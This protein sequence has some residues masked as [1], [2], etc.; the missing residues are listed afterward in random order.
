MKICL[1]IPC[2]NE[3]ESIKILYNELCETIKEINNYRVELLFIDDGS[4]D[5]TLEIIQNISNSD[6][7]VKF[8]SFSRNFGKES[9]ILAGLRFAKGD[10]I[11]VLDADLQHPPFALIN[12]IEA[13]EEGYDIAA[14]R[15]IDRNGEKKTYSWFARSFYKAINMM[16]QIKIHEGAQDFRI[17]KRKVVKAIINMP[18]YHRF[19]KGIFSWVG[20]KT[21]WFEHENRERVAGTTKWS[22][23]KSCRYA[24]DGIISF[25]TMPLRISLLTGF[26]VSMFGFV[27]ALYIV[28]K[29]LILGSDWPGFPTITSLILIMSGFILLSLGIIG[30]YIS[31]IYTEVKNRPIYII[32]KTNI[33]F[34]EQ[35][36]ER[37]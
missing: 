16:S 17:M 23:A 3:E 14:A 26:I 33:V 29:T 8:I 20:F 12:M 34:E 22:F 37:Y 19:S 11:G 21:K 6:I 7:R 13:L 24:I 9:A 4:Q 1:I 5:N 30:E 28:I 35:S 36:N 27:Y 15:R 32:D 2:Y 25:S 31:R 18:E 10:Y